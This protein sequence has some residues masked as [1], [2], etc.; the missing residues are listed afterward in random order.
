MELVGDFRATDPIFKGCYGDSLLYT[1][2]E[3]DQL[4]W[5]GIHL[6]LYGGEI[7]AL[8]APSYQQA[9]QP[10][11]MKQ[12]PPRAAT[13]SPPVE[14]PKAKHSGGKGG[15]HHGSGHSSS[16]STPKCPDSTSTKKPSSSKGP[17]S[18][19][20]ERSPK[21]RRSRKHGRSPSPSTES[22]GSKR[23][24]TYVLIANICTLCIRMHCN[25]MRCIA[26]DICRVAICLQC[27]EIDVL[28]LDIYNTTSLAGLRTAQSFSHYKY[29]EQNLNEH[30]L[31]KKKGALSKE[32][33][34]P[35]LVQRAISEECLASSPIASFFSI[36]ALVDRGGGGVPGARH[37]LWDPILSFSHFTEK[38]LRRTSTP[39][40]TGARPPPLREILGPPMLSISLEYLSKIQLCLMKITQRKKLVSNKNTLFNGGIFSWLFCKKQ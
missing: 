4:R 24:D 27:V 17:T 12:S 1:G 6:P 16:M 5:W 21:T 31:I 3:L 20:Q 36:L 11:M 30:I 33:T 9:R 14:L 18:N 25:A 7:P 23:K 19:S 10:K 32:F 8:P 22:V 40:L 29:L 39:L 34:A 15:P 37:P 35:H 2:G 13:P 26:I 28:I 38:C